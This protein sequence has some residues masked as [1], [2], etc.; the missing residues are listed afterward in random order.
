MGL[1]VKGRK[2]MILVLVLFFGLVDAEV[3]VATSTSCK[4]SNTAPPLVKANTWYTRLCVDK[5]GKRGE[6]GGQEHIVT[7]V[8]RGEEHGKLPHKLKFALQVYIFRLLR[9]AVYE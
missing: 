2:L 5:E 1:P 8:E 9:N 6:G 3:N 4:S 7:T